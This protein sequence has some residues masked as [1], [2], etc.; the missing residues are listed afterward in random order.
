MALATLLSRIPRDFVQYLVLGIDGLPEGVPASRIAEFVTTL[1]PH[2]RK[3]TTSVSIDSGTIGLASGTGV[4]GVTIDATRAFGRESQVIR[5]INRL[6]SQA[7]KAG[8]KVGVR[9]I[10]SSSVLLAC[11]AAGCEWIEG[12]TIGDAM[13][14]PPP[15][16]RFSWIDWYRNRLAE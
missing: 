11:A 5:R 10:R 13:A 6:A 15:A 9:G 16:T 7:E 2:C 4:Y 14:T 12:P 8:L 3:I 1:K